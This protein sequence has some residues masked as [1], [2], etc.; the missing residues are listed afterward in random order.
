MGH[1]KV[2]LT[3][4]LGA[5]LVLPLVGCAEDSPRRRPHVPGARGDLQQRN[6]AVH[7]PGVDAGR[8]G[9][10]RTAGRILRS[11]RAVL[12]DRTRLSE[13]AAGLPTCPSATRRCAPG[14]PRGGASPGPVEPG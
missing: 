1:G 8:Q 9:L 10:L 14:R 5:S 7:L 2:I 3:I 6:P 13:R 12:R 4:A 11:G